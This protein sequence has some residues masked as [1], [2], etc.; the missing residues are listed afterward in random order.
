MQRI[1][2]K[3]NL[4]ERD[5]TRIGK[6]IHHIMELYERRLENNRTIE[7]Q[8]EY[9]SSLTTGAVSEIKIQI[10]MYKDAR[11]YYRQHIYRG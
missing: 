7:H 3:D 9:L 6:L 2:E 4:D 10:Q 5:K 11:E 8:T 1:Y